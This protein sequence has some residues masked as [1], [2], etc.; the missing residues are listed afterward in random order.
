MAKRLCGPTVEPT[1]TPLWNLRRQDTCRTSSRTSPQHPRPMLRLYSFVL[2]FLARCVCPRFLSSNGPLTSSVPNAPSQRQVLNESAR[3]LMTLHQLSPP[4]AHGNVRGFS[5]SRQ[6]LRPRLTYSLR[7]A[8]CL[9]S[10]RP[11]WS[12]ALVR[13][14]S[15]EASA[16]SS[17]LGSA[18]FIMPAR[19]TRDSSVSQASHLPARSALA[20]D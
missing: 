2:P 7:R 3:S 4:V 5:L 16:T 18:A 10:K 17:W 9:R 15:I 19:S 8:L 6:L 11:S 20:I 1:H 12:S 13:S 14:P